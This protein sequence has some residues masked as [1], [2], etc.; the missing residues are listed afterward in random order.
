[1]TQCRR[2][3]YVCTTQCRCNVQTAAVIVFEQHV[4]SVVC[5][6]QQYLAKALLRHETCLDKYTLRHKKNPAAPVPLTLCLS[7]CTCANAL[8]APCCDATYYIYI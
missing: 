5:A 7:T 4:T 6:M 2:V 8:P 1:M 3:Y